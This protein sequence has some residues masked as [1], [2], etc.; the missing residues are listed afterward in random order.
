MKKVILL[1]SV[2]L[3]LTACSEKP[4]EIKTT[5]TIN[6]TT[7]PMNIRFFGAFLDAG[8][9]FQGSIDEIELY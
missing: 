6:Q 8:N 3:A 2:V 9:S 4:Q 5:T 7:T 1:V